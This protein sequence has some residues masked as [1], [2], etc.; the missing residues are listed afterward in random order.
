VDIRTADLYSGYAIDIGT[1]VAAPHVSGALALLLG[2]FPSL[3]ADQQQAALDSGA[4]DLGAAGVDSDFGWGRLDALASYLWLANTPDFTVAVSPS[5]A[6]ASAGSSAAYTVSLTSQNG[7]ASDVSL[8]LTGLS[9]SQASWSFTPAVV[10]SGAGTAQLSV[11]TAASIPPG[12]YPLTIVGTSGSLTRA[13]TATLVVPGPPD[14]SLSASPSSQS[15]A[16]G[17]GV[18][19]SVA[20]GAMNGFTGDVALSLT[21]LPASVGTAVFTPP[22]ITSAGNSQLAIT[23]AATAPTGSYPL[24]ITGTSGSISHSV[25]VTLVVAPPPDFS[26][27]VIPGTRTVSA[28]GTAGYTLTLGSL[29]SFTGNIALSLNGLPSSGSGSSQLAVTTTASAPAGSYPLTIIGSSGPISHSVPV[30]LIVSVQDFSLSASPT[31]I[32]VNRGQTAS[33]TVFVSSLGG[34][35]GSISLS[36]SGIP[37]GSSTSFSANPVAAPGSC[38]L[39]VRTTGSTSRG[40]FTIRITGK[41]ERSSTRSL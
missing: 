9:A 15:V 31:T 5:S 38:T 30:T 11:Q 34:F 20:V 16:A 18:S 21:G 7:F 19:Y 32:T 4:P 39:K 1:S 12:S 24:T 26:I 17:N 8:S 27:A 33:Y 28:G 14:F 10:P 36:L 6:T 3:S 25:S 2:A 29:N 22:T 41:S 13:T 35:T 37:T 23:T 40:T